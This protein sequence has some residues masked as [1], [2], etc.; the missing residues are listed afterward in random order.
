MRVAVGWRGGAGS[1]GGLAHGRLLYNRYVVLCVWH[2]QLN[3][4]HDTL[5]H[6]AINCS[7]RVGCVCVCCVSTAVVCVLQGLVWKQLARICDKSTV[8]LRAQLRLQGVQIEAQQEEIERLQL[9]VQQ[10]RGQLAERDA[11]LSDRDAR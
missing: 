8:C 3:C 6:V 2:A 5:Q 1:D 4:L 9:E 7:L 10:L 11:K